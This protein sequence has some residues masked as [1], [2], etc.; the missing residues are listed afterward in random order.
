MADRFYSDSRE[1]ECVCVRES[2]TMFHQALIS[3]KSCLLFRFAPTT[4]ISLIKAVEKACHFKQS[5]HA[6]VHA[7]SNARSFLGH[8]VM[9]TTLTANQLGRHCFVRSQSEV[10]R[11]RGEQES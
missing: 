5:A 11:R 8:V 6:A 2:E 7:H 10:G 4:N 1:S 9:G 3:L